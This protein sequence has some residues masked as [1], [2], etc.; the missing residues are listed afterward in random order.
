MDTDLLIIGEDYSDIDG[1]NIRVT[2]TSRVTPVDLA[3]FIEAALFSPSDDV[4]AGSYDQQQEWFSDEAEDRAI[5]LLRSSED[6]DVNAI[7]RTVQRELTW[8]LPKDRSVTIRIDGPDIE[9][10]GLT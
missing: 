5:T 8:R 6:A 1:V 9:I 3:D 7:I 4:E 2:A 10:A